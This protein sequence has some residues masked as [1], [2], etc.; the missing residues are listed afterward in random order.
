MN[1]NHLDLNSLAFLNRCE[2]AQF[3]I[4]R[5]SN[6][7]RIRMRPVIGDFFTEISDDGGASFLPIFDNDGTCY[8]ETFA[9]ALNAIVEHAREM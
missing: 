7:F 1:A 9:A 5:N 4:G 3:D 2:Q 8:Y 6:H